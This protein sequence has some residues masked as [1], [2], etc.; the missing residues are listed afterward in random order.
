MRLLAAV[1]LLS[2]VPLLPQG[3]ASRGIKPQ[4][5]PKLSGKPWPSSLVNVAAKAGLNH[6]LIYGAERDVQYVSET[7]SG[8]VAFFDYD[9][10]GYPDIFFA[11]GTRFGTP[12]PDSGNHLYHNNKDGTFTDVTEKSGVSRAGWGQGVAVADYDNDGYLDLFVTYWGENALYRNNH[13]GTFTDLARKVGLIAEAAY[14]YWYSGATWLDYDRDGR[15]DLFVATYIDFDLPKIPKPGQSASCNWKG[16]LTPCGPRGLKTGRQFL[17]HQKPDG[18]FEDVSKRSGVGSAR[19]SFGLTAISTDLDGDGWPDIYLACDS[20]PSLFFRN[21]HDGTFSEEGI[22]RGIAL[23]DDGMEQAGMGLVIGDFNTDGVLDI[24]KTHFA[25][26]TH[27]LYEGL[28]KGQYKDVTQSSGIGVETR[29]IAWGAGMPDLDNDGLPDL[30]LVTGNV[31]PDT[32]RDLPAYPSR[33]PPL[34]FRNLGGGRFEQLF[35]AQAG[36]AMDEMHSSRGAAF[37]DFDN[38]GDLDVVV[39]NRN[40]TPALYRNDLK[41]SNHWL[42]VQLEGTVSNRAAI[43]A[44]VTVEYGDRKQTQAVLSQSSFTSHNDLRLNFGLGAATQAVLTIRWPNGQVTRHTAKEVD[45]LIKLKEPA[46]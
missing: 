41:S 46:N 14:P 17:Y 44:Q 28:G 15:L 11:G 5:R 6:V 20:T 39:W 16:V 30:F 7:S 2:A 33:M 32:E 26:D 31:Y 24:F 3:M 8:G 21:S 1:F 19:S 25:D 27:I 23:N 35:S 9:N 13:D 38:D 10:D 12:P 22:E 4:P 42:K 18:T 40:E 29:F 37:G 36:P 43:G 45:R 34:L